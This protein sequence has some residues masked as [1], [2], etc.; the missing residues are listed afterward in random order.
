VDE[1]AVMSIRFRALVSY[2]CGNAYWDS[3][4]DV[5]GV[6]PQKPHK[7]RLISKLSTQPNHPKVVHGSRK[8]YQ[9][10]FRGHFSGIAKDS[11]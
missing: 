4:T 5:K 9:A 10:I 3:S 6:T 7:S 2:L 1:T 11:P 8:S